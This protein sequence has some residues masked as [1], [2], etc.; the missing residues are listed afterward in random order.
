MDETIAQS[1][2]EKLRKG[3]EQQVLISNQDFMVFRSQLVLQPDRE[4]F[5]G[6][7]QKNGEVIYTYIAAERQSE[8]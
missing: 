2:L 6:N 1:W 8:V 4:C 5:V 7:A 3:E